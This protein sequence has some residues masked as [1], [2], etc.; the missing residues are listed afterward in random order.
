MVAEGKDQILKI[1]NQVPALKGW[2]SYLLWEGLPFLMTL[3]VFGLIS[4]VNW[5]YE[6]K[7]VTP[8]HSAADWSHV[9]LGLILLAI[10]M[11]QALAASFLLF[12]VR[13]VIRLAL[14]NPSSGWFMFVP[15]TLISIFLIFPSLF[16]IILGPAGITM[17]EQTNEAPR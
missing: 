12:I 13:V 16:I 15:L 4:A 9:H 11:G 1:M 7:L 3:T 5:G 14:P 8:D 17:I 10:A 2:K 6:S